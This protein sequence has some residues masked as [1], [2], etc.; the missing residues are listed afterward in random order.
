MPSLLSIAQQV[1]ELVKSHGAVRAAKALGVSR[2]TAMRVAA[3]LPVRRGSQLVI[4]RAL[5]T[6]TAQPED[7]SGAPSHHTED[8]SRCDVPMR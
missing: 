4:E 8:D 3:G 6:S 2:E 5:Q 1:H 7:Q